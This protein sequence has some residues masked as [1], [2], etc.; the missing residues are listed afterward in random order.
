MN[1]DSSFTPE[2][3]AKLRQLLEVEAIRELRQRYS[4]CLDTLQID[5]LADLYTENAL[6][7]FGPYG[8]WRGRE[9][10]RENYRGVMS[11]AGAALFNSMHHSTNHSVEL[12]S[13][14]RATGRSYLIDVVTTTEKTTQPVLWYGVYDEDYKKVSGK[15]LINRC[16]LQFLWPERHLSAGF[17]DSFS[18]VTT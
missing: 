7:E 11:G 16:S 5:N 2:E 6:C 13:A 14:T 15:W 18:N 12:V 1:N 10:I 3:I 9:T 17:V 4:T 8:E